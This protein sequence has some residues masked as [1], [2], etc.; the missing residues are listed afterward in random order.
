L[1]VTAGLAE[2]DTKL[3]MPPQK[4]NLCGGVFVSWKSGYYFL[5]LYS[6]TTASR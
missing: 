4:K 3:E 5:L 6:A 1:L 2:D